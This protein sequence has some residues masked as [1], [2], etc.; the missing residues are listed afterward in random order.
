MGGSRMRQPAL[1]MFSVEF[2]QSSLP[3]IGQGEFDPSFI[4]TKLGAKTSRMLVAGVIDSMERRDT[5]S[6]PGYRG[7]LRDPSGL[8]MFDVAPFNPELHAD[9][10]EV[11]AKFERGDRFL[12]LMLGRSRHYETEDG[13]VFT[14]IRAEA[15]SEIDSKRYHTWLARTAD[16]TMRRIDAHRR[17]KELDAD[18]GVYRNA[19]IPTDLIDGMI[20]ARSHYGDVDISAYEL[21]VMHAISMGEGTPPPKEAIPEADATEPAPAQPP[22][23]DLSQTSEEDAKTMAKAC[24]LDVLGSASE[25]VDYDSLIRSC[26][27]IGVGRLAAEEVIDDLRDVDAMIVEETFGYFS[28]L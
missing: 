18:A 15:F 25:P 16:S 23:V 9:A 13:G 5:E 8:H 4:V 1:R 28:L 19:G 11:L 12:M 6:G 24:I 22:V 21:A 14:S 7:R 20:R 3:I 17:A 10:E 27:D 26:L 2:S